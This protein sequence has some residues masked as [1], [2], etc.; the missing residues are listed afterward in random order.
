MV[1]GPGNIT[2]TSEAGTKIAVDKAELTLEWDPNQ[3]RV[4]NSVP[5]CA[6]SGNRFTLVAQ[7]EAPRELGG[8]WPFALSGGTIMLAPVDPKGESNSPQPHRIARQ[9]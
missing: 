4:S 3:R 9:V 8:I 5:D 7:A 2:D 1:V 6:A